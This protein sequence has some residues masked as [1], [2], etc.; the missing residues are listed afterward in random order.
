M[1]CV[2]CGPRQDN[3]LTPFILQTDWY[4]QPEHGGFY[5]ALASGLYRDAGLHVTILQ[6]GPNSNSVE[7]GLTGRADVAMNRLDTL[8]K[9]RGNGVP[10][11][12]LFSTLQHDPQALMLHRSNPVSN[13]SE[14]DG[15]QIQAVPGQAWIEYLEQHYEMQLHVIPHDFGLERFMADPRAIVQCLETS[16]PYYVRQNNLEPKILPLRSA[17]FDPYHVVYTSSNRLLRNPDVFR[18]FIE[19]SIK[20]WK[21]YIQS[22][23]SAAHQLIAKNNPHMSEDFME[24]SRRQ[25]IEKQLVMDNDP[26]SVGRID[27]ERVDK[28]HQ[29]LLELEILDQPLDLD[30]MIADFFRYSD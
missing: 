13:L 5:Y 24:W 7:K 14:L 19:A 30:S 23:P 1:G 20:G 6:G 17:G 27:S 10:L 26:Q 9:I 12:A 15:A 18:R 11:V 28:L 29:T 22:D 3:G 21:A 8:M 25:L 2:G 16:E 4:A